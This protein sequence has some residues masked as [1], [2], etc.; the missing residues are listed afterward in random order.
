VRPWARLEELSHFHCR[1]YE[2]GELLGASFGGRPTLVQ[3]QRS[4]KGLGQDTPPLGK[5][6][7]GSLHRIRGI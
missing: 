2:S 3:V 7:E 1:L 6:T 5:I 4:R